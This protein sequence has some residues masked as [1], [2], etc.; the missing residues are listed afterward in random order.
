MN[1]DIKDTI[2]LDNDKE[3]VVVSKANYKDKIYYFLIDI[4]D[5]S[6]VKFCYEKSSNNALI[7]IDDADL[8]K[9]LLPILTESAISK[10][11]LSKLNQ[12]D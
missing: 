8:I 5:N 9:T 10:I 1:I 7:E 12:A 4:N 3:Y 2:T 6:N 11:D